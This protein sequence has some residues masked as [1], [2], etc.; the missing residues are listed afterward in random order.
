MNDVHFIHD[1]YNANPASTR[2]GIETLKSIKPESR[3]ILVFADML[4]LGEQ[5]SE[6]HRKVGH[7]IM[8]A[9][10]DHVFLV[11]MEAIETAQHLDNSNF[12]SYYHNVEKAATIERFLRVIGAGDLVYLKGSRGMRLEDFIEAYKERK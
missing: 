2:I 1:A 3:K 6:M 12:I 11:G 5:S 4:E 7:F 9:D 8:E 10:F